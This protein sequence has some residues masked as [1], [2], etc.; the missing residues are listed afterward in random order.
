TFLKILNNNAIGASF[1]KISEVAGLIDSRH[2][3]DSLFKD[4]K[5]LLDKLLHAP[6]LVT[7][8]YEP[9]EEKV[10]MTLISHLGEYVDMES[11]NR[12]L[13]QQLGQTYAVLKI[14]ILG[15]P[16][17]KILNGKTNQVWYLAYQ[18]GNLIYSVSLNAME[19]SLV[20]SHGDAVHFSQQEDWKRL[21]KTAGKHV[22]G[23]LYL[24]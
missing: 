10:N 6:L 11:L 1:S 22:D 4:K 2:Q 9:L 13:A 12:Y 16:T 7:A 5:Y 20:S 3:L 21:K 19:N 15:I 18:A 23:R 8:E 14:D 17:L 24:Q